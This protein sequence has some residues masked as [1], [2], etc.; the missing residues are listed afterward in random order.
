MLND[1]YRPI[2]RA[3]EKMKLGF[4]HLCFV[5]GRAGIGKSHQIERCLRQFRLKYFEVNGDVSEA[6]VYRIL[7]EH[8]GEVIWFKDVVRLLKGLRSIDMLKSACETKPERRIT[9]LNYS[10]K[11][12]DLPREFIFTGKLIFD[13]NSLVGLKFREDFE[14]LTSRGDFVDMIFSHAEM[15][16]I[17][18]LICRT[19]EQ[20][21]VTEF[22]IANYAYS[23]FN[24]LNLRTQ[25]KA[26]QTHRYAQQTGRDWRQ[27]V[28]AELHNQRSRVLKY[29][30]P[31]AGDG[32][33][34][35]LD[36]KRY[37]VRSGIVSTVRT[38]ERRI[39]DWLEL[40]DLYRVSDGERNFLVSL[41]PVSIGLRPVP[42]NAASDTSD[43]PVAVTPLG[44]TSTAA[45]E[46]DLPSLPGGEQ[47]LNTTACFHSTGE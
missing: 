29:L 2:E 21:E 45:N 44:D 25:Q 18:R 28:R 39:A 38:A 8:N 37:L 16:E 47:S 27:E 30:Y 35:T 26:L 23:G 41:F 7:V 36:L 17:M 32:P 43:T 34:R 14:A 20:R 42:E 13:F 15:C 40:G 9:C 46:V 12:Q 19:P 3:I 11:Q 1:Y 24:M 22:L 6:Y 33:I 10:D 4:S 5:R 31:I